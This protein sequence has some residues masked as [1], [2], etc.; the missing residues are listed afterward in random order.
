MSSTKLF[1]QTLTMRLSIKQYLNKY[2]STDFKKEYLKEN[3]RMKTPI[4]KVI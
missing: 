1:R 4:G 3:I 2:K